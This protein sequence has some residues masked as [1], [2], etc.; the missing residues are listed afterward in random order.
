MGG[1]EFAWLDE[2][3]VTSALETV[4]DR[5]LA[6]VEKRKTQRAAEYRILAADTRGLSLRQ[7]MFVRAMLSCQMRPS[8]AMR[9]VNEGLAAADRLK[10][11]TVSRWMKDGVFKS[12]LERYTQLLLDYTGVAS[13]AQTLLRI[14]AV[15]ED[16][17][18]PVPMYHN[19][20]ALLNP[21]TGAIQKEVDRGAAL[22]GLELL[23]KASGV[24]RKDEENSQRVTVVLDFS[25]EQMQGEQESEVIEGEAH[26]VP[27]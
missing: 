25:G 8:V 11:T 4:F 5:P 27:Q 14:D 18:T 10:Q 24:F 23:G 22:K 21:E 26:E 7:R 6:P 3:G 12:I 9:K 19:G 13:P 15:V 2:P 17:L 20:I 16:A 1:D